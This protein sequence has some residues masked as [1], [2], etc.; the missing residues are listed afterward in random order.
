VATTTTTIL[1]E[2]VVHVEEIKDIHILLVREVPSIIE[3]QRLDLDLD[4][5][6]VHQILVQVLQNLREN[7]LR[8]WK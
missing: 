3:G 1:S 2:V 6:N 5:E 4:L 8:K 7:L